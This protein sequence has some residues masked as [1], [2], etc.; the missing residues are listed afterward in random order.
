[1]KPVFTRLQA[2]EGNISVPGRYPTCIKPIQ[3]ILV[4]K[5]IGIGIIKTGEVKLECILIAVIITGLVFIY[6]S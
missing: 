4:V 1:M 3:F 2:K 6:I 5:I